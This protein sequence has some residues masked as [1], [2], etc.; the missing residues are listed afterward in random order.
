MIAWSDLDV[1]F[2]TRDGRARHVDGTGTSFDPEVDLGPGVIPFLIARP[3]GDFLVVWAGPSASDPD[4]GILARTLSADASG[5]G[6]PFQVNANGP[7]WQDTPRVAFDA[8]GSFMVTWTD[9]SGRDSSG[10]GVYARAFDAAGLPVGDDLLVNTTT[11]FDQDTS[12]IV[13]TSADHYFAAWTDWSG[14][15]GSSGGV[16]AQR[17][18]VET[19]EPSAPTVTLLRPNGGEQLCT[20][21]PFRIRWSTFGADQLD[22]LNVAVSTDLGRH[23]HSIAGC[24]HLEA[25]ATSCLWRSPAPAVRGRALVRVSARTLA[26][27]LISDVSD[28]PFTIRSGG[29]PH[30]HAGQQGAGPR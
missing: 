24:Q 14:H 7:G 25:S 26:H 11:Q 30:Q 4:G 20:G 1:D 19:E 6:A 18:T 12:A 15:D 17:L 27:G 5:L 21:S 16:Y 23:F 28:A 3:S 8:L 13:A 9:H 10:N 29:G 22:Y 2:V